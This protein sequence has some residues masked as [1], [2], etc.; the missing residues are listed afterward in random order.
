MSG[1]ERRPWPHDPRYLA[2]DDGT[3]VGPSGRVLSPFLGH[4]GYPR[5]NTY[6]G[7]KWSQ[8]FVHVIVC[9]TFHGPRPDGMEVAHLNGQ[10]TDVR[11]NNL[12]WKSRVEN[13][14]DKLAHGTGLQG[15]RHHQHKLTE[16]QVR[17]I[18]AS[19]AGSCALARTYPVEPSTIRAIRRRETWRHI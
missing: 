18:R 4:Q 16:D 6:R 7:G 14:A 9:E 15:E 10:R 12:Q 19:A 11:A 13:E 3:V 17:A 2:G 1:T 8:H 5:I